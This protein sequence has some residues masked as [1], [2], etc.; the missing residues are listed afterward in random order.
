[1]KANVCQ[2]NCKDHLVTA[3]GLEHLCWSTHQPCFLPVFSLQEIIS[4]PL[5]ITSLST[6]STRYLQT[7]HTSSCLHS[8]LPFLLLHLLTLFPSYFGQ[9]WSTLNH[10][11]AAPVRPNSVL[12]SFSSFLLT[13]FVHFSDH[14]AQRQPVYPILN[15][16]CTLFTTSWLLSK[17]SKCI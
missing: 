14:P 10:S 12:V 5:S 2:A 15:K 8:P 13:F 7:N 17:D 4:Q 16:H 6:T 9:R 1:M 3:L 11:C